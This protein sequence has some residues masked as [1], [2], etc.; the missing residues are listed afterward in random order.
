MAPSRA[1]RGRALRWEQQGAAHP[2]I[3]E[4]PL[5][6]EAA[7]N[8]LKVKVYAR[9]GHRR[10]GLEGHASRA[11]EPIRQMQQEEVAEQV[12]GGSNAHHGL[13]DKG[14]NS[15]E[16]D[17]LRIKMQRANLVMRGRCIEEIR[18]GGIKPAQRA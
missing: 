3:D 8:R 15:K 13:A 10:D 5:L 6:P 17:V 16:D 11:L 14:K 12:H 9:A 18:E 1:R 4:H 2:D 7:N